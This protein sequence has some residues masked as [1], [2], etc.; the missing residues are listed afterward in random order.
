MHCGI[1]YSSKD[2]FNAVLEFSQKSS[3]ESFCHCLLTGIETLCVT[4]TTVISVTVMTTFSH[5]DIISI[6]LIQ[7]TCIYEQLGVNVM[8]GIGTHPSRVFSRP[9]S[10]ERWWGL[11]M[12]R[13]MRDCLGGRS[14]PEE[15]NSSGAPLCVVLEPAYR[16]GRQTKLMRKTCL[17]NLKEPS[18]TA[19]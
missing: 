8:L 16:P 18:R 2:P 5:S 12:S 9:E 17:I 15:S 11:P 19:H 7:P 6:D 14:G 10:G 1:A 4:M 3:E 13:S